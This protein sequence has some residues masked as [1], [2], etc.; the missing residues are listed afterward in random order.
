M[1]RPDSGAPIISPFAIIP[2]ALKRPLQSCGY[3][4]DLLRSDFRAFAPALADLR[5]ACELEPEARDDSPFRLWLIRCRLG[6]KEAADKDLRAFVE[7]SRSL[8]D[9]PAKI[10]R[11]LSGQLSEPDFLKASSNATQRCQAC[12]YAASKR[13]LQGRPS[14]AT[15]LLAQC[16]ATGAKTLPEY[17][18]AAA[19]LT[20]L[21]PAKP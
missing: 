15:N 21:A 14:A 8:D 20:F 19:E 12:F 17:Q 4:R 13:L 9:W 1:K 3:R 6:D 16:L 2:D 10:A 18:S 7:K 11:F 5:K